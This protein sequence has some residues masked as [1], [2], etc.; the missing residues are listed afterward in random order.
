MAATDP[1]CSVMWQFGTDETVALY[2]PWSFV[3]GVQ[4]L[5]PSVQCHR[6]VSCLAPTAH[7][8]SAIL[9]DGV[10]VAWI[11]LCS[12]RAASDLHHD[13]AIPQPVPSCHRCAALVASALRHACG[14]AT[15]L[16]TMSA[17]TGHEPTCT[18]RHRVPVTIRAPPI[19][20]THA[21]TRSRARRT[22][23]HTFAHTQTRT[24]LA[25]FV[26]H[27]SAFRGLPSPKS[28]GRVPSSVCR[29]RTTGSSRACGR[30]ISQTR[31]A[32]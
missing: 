8:A 2:I 10:A 27:Q 12:I 16:P 23:S 9:P 31:R 24:T 5:V 1:R 14:D 22:P 21:R 32:T 19:I 13:P 28:S 26:N 29:C 17:R 25:I 30:Q 4:G 3:Q 18:T 20:R 11:Q 15:V 7:I 6:A